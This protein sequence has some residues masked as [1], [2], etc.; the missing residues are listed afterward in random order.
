MENAFQAAGRAGTALHTMAVLQTYQ[1]DLLKELSMCGGNV[2]EEV[3][4][5]LCQATDL[6]LHM[7][8]QTAPAISR[9]MG[10]MVATERHL[11]LNLSGIK[12]RDKSFSFMLP[13]H[14]PAY[15]IWRTLSSVGSARLSDA[16]RSL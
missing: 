13:N 9:S 15:S 2:N 12:E 1:T 10:A 14:L 5:E 11:W 16:R 3:F 4:A 8:K 7:T 6:S